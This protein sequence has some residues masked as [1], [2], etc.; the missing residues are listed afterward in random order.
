[1][2]DLQ[3]QLSTPDATTPTDAPPATPLPSARPRFPKV[4]VA[5][6]AGVYDAGHGRKYY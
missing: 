1:M 3:S 6:K 5:V 2:T 4:K